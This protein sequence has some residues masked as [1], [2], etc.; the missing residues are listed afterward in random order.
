MRRIL[1]LAL[2]VWA[3]VAGAASV[4][5]L[6]IEGRLASVESR[7][8]IRHAVASDALDVVET[9]KDYLESRWASFNRVALWHAATATFLGAFS[10]W[11]LLQL[12]KPSSLAT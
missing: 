8:A 5:I 9:D 6:V 7:H 12:R 3:L 1:Y 4:R 11:N 2:L 10:C